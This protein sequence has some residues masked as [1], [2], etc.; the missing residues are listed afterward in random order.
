MQRHGWFRPHVADFSRVSTM[1]LTRVKFSGGGVE[2]WACVFAQ[3]P[4][5]GTVMYSGASP[6]SK[7][8]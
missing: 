1:L 3:G 6:K 7:E 2:T 8:R 4:V 5:V